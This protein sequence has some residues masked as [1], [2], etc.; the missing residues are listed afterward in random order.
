LNPI[1]NEYIQFL[2]DKTNEARDLLDLPF[3]DGGD[4]LMVN[5]NYIPIT[6]VGKQYTKGSD[7]NE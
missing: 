2:K 5:G 6:E 7:N 1:F 4:I 3:A